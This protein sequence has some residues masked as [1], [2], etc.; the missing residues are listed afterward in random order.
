MRA[1]QAQLFDREQ[2]ARGMAVKLR[3]DDVV[4]TPWGKSGTT[5]TQQIVHTLRTRGDM[6]FDDISRVVPWIEMSPLLGLDLNAE[7]P[8]ETASV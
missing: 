1:L 2:I 7:Q 4:I 6:A 5:W 8:S 3:P